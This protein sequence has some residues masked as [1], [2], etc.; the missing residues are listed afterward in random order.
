[1]L[2]SVDAHNYELT[3]ST[4]AQHETG[5]TGLEACWGCT[6]STERAEPRPGTWQA[7]THSVCLPEERTCELC[8]LVGF[9]CAL[10][11]PF[12]SFSHAQLAECSVTLGPAR[13]V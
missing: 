5:I 1:M 6:V 7:Q 10:C 12:S 8:V 3:W 2:P 4:C 11:L 13:L 9:P